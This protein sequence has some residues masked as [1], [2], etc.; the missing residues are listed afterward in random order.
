MQ[1]VII[2]LGRIQI[3]KLVIK[4]IYFEPKIVTSKISLVFIAGKDIIMYH[5]F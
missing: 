1:S 3:L 5:F 4:V 2:I